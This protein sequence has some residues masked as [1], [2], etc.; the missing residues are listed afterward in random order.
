MSQLPDDQLRSLLKD[1]YQ[2]LQGQYEDY[3][4][5][6]LTIKGWISFASVAAIALGFGSDKTGARGEIWLIV[7]IV[8]LSIWYLEGRW[9]LFQYAFRDRIRTIE[10][11]FRGDADL[12]DKNTRPF[13]IYHAWFKSY[14][15]QPIFPYER[16]FRPRPFL[17]R[18]AEAMLQDFV[19]LPYLPIIVICLYL[20]FRPH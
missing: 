6:S 12:I 3:D 18:L 16:E 20:Y 14:A 8:A 10:A 7:A 13:Q 19:F 17:R 9:K 11:I 4:R 15:D 1:E 5:R 2:I